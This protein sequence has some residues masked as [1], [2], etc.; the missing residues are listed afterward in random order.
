[1]DGSNRDSVPLYKV[2]EKWDIAMAALYISSDAGKCGVWCL[3]C[4]NTCDVMWCA[5]CLHSV[6]IW[7]ERVPSFPPVET[8]Y[9]CIFNL[10][11]HDMTWCSSLFLEGKYVNGTTLIVDGGLWL[12]HPRYLHKDAVKE[13]S[14]TVEKKSRDAPVG[15]PSSKLWSPQSSPPLSNTSHQQLQQQVGCLLCFARKGKIKESNI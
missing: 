5:V 13:L 11:W 8:K 9:C 4:Y 12:S 7:I 2:G 10:V 15:V 14:R 6:I 3:H 1:M